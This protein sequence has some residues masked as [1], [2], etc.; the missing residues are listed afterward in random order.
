MSE[1]IRA[2]LVGCGGICHAWMSTPSL[3]ELT[4]IVGLVDLSIDNAKKVADT[5]KLGDVEISDDLTATLDKL[6]PEVVFD[7]TVPTAHAGVTLSALEHGC[8]VLGEKPLA[9]SMDNARKMIKAAKAAGKIY[10]VIQ[11]RRYQP[12]I[13]RLRAFIESGVIGD[14]TT[15]HC[16]FLLDADFGENFRKHM[17]HVLIHDMAIHTFDAARYITQA[18]PRSVYCQEWNPIDSCYDYDASASAIFEMSHGIVYTYQGSWC[19]KG[20]NTTWECDWHIIGTKGSVS[21]DGADAFRVEVKAADGMISP[22]VPEIDPG[23]KTNGHDGNIREFLS[24]VRNGGIPE[25]DA[26]DNINSLAM[27]LAAVESAQDGA[28]IHIYEETL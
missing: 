24:C 7:L 6:K 12:T 9:D 25:T 1:K 16:R 21:W 15:V 28:K 10:A 19:P 5:F 13:R 18:T 27:V 14:I 11:N 3:L 26:S 2:V 23:S 8:H 4:E 20:L 22:E 17:H